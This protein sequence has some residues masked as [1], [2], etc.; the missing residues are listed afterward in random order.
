MLGS[1]GSTVYDS[2]PTYSSTVRVKK[3]NYQ[4]KK[5][6]YTIFLGQV[7]KKQKR[8]LGYKRTGETQMFLGNFTSICINDIFEVQSYKIENPYYGEQYQV[9]TYHRIYPGTLDELR[10]FLLSRK[11]RVGPKR[12]DQLLERH[13]LDTLFAIEH[14]PHAFD[15]LPI[16]QSYAE[17][18][19]R[20]IIESR[21]FEDTLVLL[22]ACGLD[23]RYAMPLFNKYHEETLTCLQ[24]SPYTPYLDGILDFRTADRLNQAMG[25]SF[26]TDMRVAMTVYATLRFDSDRVGNLYLSRNCLPARCEDFLARQKTQYRDSRPFTEAEYEAALTYL[27]RR[28]LIC[29]DITIDIKDPPIYLYYNHANEI[30]IVKYLQGIL[31]GEKQFAFA[32]PDIQN[33]LSD[34]E[35]K[36]G[37]SLASEQRAAVVMALTNTVSILTGGP[38]TGKTQTINAIIS[39]IHALA[40][41]AKIKL[42]APTGKAAN[43]MAELTQTDACTIHRMIGLGSFQTKSVQPGQLDCDF[44]V[45]DEFSMA[46]AYLTCRLLLSASTKAQ[47]LFVGDFDQLPSVGP[48]LVLR[49]FINSDCIPYTRLNIIFRQAKKSRIVENAQRI[50]SSTS[51]CTCQSLKCAKH[52]NG[53]FYFIEAT[54]TQLIQKAILCSIKRLLQTGAYTID[55]IQVLSP[56]RKPVL[57]VDTLNVLLRERFNPNTQSV[58]FQDREFRIGDRVIHIVNNYE[59]SVFNGETGTV[60]SIAYQADKT[61]EVAFP[62]RDVW[63]GIKDL[64]QLE[65]AYATSVHRAQGSEFPVVIMPIHETLSTA[66]NRNILYTAITRARQMIVLIG[67]KTALAE[68]I[69]KDMTIER[70]SNLSLRLKRALA[71]STFHSL[72]SI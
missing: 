29:A 36:T 26:N 11:M 18:L 43:R 5:D 71:S 21:T 62:Y 54:N 35:Q 6:G 55:D 30:T 33:F 59:L 69:H 34:Y 1:N 57:G 51:A 38:G 67:S 72:P 46:D 23:H 19:R 45:I 64:E 56:L 8:N 25:H 37:L 60:K 27:A 63:Y 42:A 10:A 13:G 2:S 15:G 22:Q 40:P 52:P 44:L 58:S 4:E 28:E 48:G 32:F 3:I 24:T 50:I 7:L 14:D 47:I 9:I 53:D 17:A 20:E 65:L 41:S 66:L 31:T 12:V 68:G 49:D 70:N 61:V 39:A 16:P